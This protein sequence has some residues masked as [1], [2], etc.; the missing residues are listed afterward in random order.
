[1]SRVH[2]TIDRLVLHGV[3][4]ADKDGLVN[5]MK[6]ELARLLGDAGSEADWG[7]SRRTPVVRLEQ[8]PL[9]PGPAG[10]RTFGQGIARGIG[11]EVKR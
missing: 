9:E 7:G 10:A 4:P 8:M 1:M 11:K 5:G 3:D 2:V 6:A